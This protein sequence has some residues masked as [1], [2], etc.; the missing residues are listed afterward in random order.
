MK[1]VA[2]K[3]SIPCAIVAGMMV[4]AAGPARADRLCGW[5]NNPAPNNFW[6]TDRVNDWVLSVQG[7]GSVPGF[8]TMPDMTRRGWIT[9]NPGGHGY[10]CACVTAQVDWRTRRITR[11]IKADAMPLDLC[12]RDPGLPRPLYQVPVPPPGE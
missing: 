6:L 9:T 3:L 11:L 8:T 1:R 4:I 2:T 7:D 12:Q 5:I 10:G